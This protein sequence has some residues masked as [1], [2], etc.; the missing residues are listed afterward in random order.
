MTRVE[1]ND[2]EIL[3]IMEKSSVTINVDCDLKD[4]KD[5]I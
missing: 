1:V 4:N 3:R 2:M 5:A